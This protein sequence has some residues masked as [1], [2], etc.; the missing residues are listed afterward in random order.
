MLCTICIIYNASGNK[1]YMV[2]Y[3]G[4]KVFYEG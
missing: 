4:Y 2:F 3:V 1:K